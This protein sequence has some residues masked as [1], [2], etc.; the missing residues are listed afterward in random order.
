M[1]HPNATLRSQLLSNRLQLQFRET[2]DRQ[3]LF[4][5]VVEKFNDQSFNSGGLVTIHR[6]FTNRSIN[7]E[8]INASGNITSD[9]AYQMF[10]SVRND[11]AKVM[12]DYQKSGQHNSHDF[13]NYCNGKIDI[14]Y[15]HCW[16]QKIGDPELTSFCSEGSEISQGIDTTLMTPTSSSSEI[17]QTSND[18]RKRQNDSFM[19]DIAA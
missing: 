17:K 13:F 19:S 8:A 16:L 18:K 9:I 7:P 5:D 11:Y 10:K 4:T 14:L 2:G 6:E 1:S 3:P 12:K 15:L